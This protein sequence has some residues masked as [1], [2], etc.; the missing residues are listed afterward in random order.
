MKLGAIEDLARSAALAPD[1]LTV[2]SDPERIASLG[3]GKG[4]GLYALS[5]AGIAVPSWVILSSGLCTRFL[6]AAG[7]VPVIGGLLAAVGPGEVDTIAERI[8]DAI[9]GADDGPL[10]ELVAAALAE[11]GTECVAVRSS[12]SE[13]DGGRLSFAGQYSSFLNL[14][15]PAEIVRYVKKCWASAYS[16]RCLAYRLQHRLPLRVEATACILQVMVDAAKS[17]VMFTSNPL[18]N[19]RAEIMISAVYGLGEGLVSGLVDAD[20]YVIGHVDGALRRSEIGEKREHLVPRAGGGHE[21]VRTEPVLADALCLSCDEIA[22]LHGCATAI[23]RLFGVP[24][25]VEWAID[26]QGRL[27]ILQARPI[28]SGPSPLLDA[29]GAA[30]IWENSNISESFGGMTAPLTFSFA[31]DVYHQVFKEYCRILGVPRRML[32]HMDDWLFDMLGH[33]NGRV[34]YNLLNWYKVLRLAP[35]YRI[36]WQMLEFSIGAQES[37]SDA[38]KAALEPLA[39]ASPVFRRLIYARVAWRSFLYFFAIE[40]SVG[41]FLRDFARL[42]SRYDAI[43]YRQLPIGE[44]HRIFSAL[45]H[46][47]IAQFGRMIVLEQ[48]ISLT[49]GCLALL[50]RRWLPDAPTGFLLEMTRPQGML[51]SLEP[52]RR[53]TALVEFVEND[54][55]LLELV[56]TT[57]V[58][59]M[60]AVL[61]ASSLPATAAFRAEIEAYIDAFGYRCVNE[62][63]LEEPDIREDPTVFFAMLKSNLGLGRRETGRSE[64][65]G[66]QAY[67]QSRLGWPKRLVY[68]AVRRKARRLLEARERVRF[69]RTRVF[70]TARRMIKAMGEKLVAAGVVADRHDIF[71]LRLEELTGWFGGTVPPQELRPLIALRRQLADEQVGLDAPGRFETVGVIAS[72]DYARQGWRSAGMT[73]GAAPILGGVLSG[74]PCCPGSV[75]GTARLVSEPRDLGGG[76]LVTYR[77]DPGWCPILPSASALLIERGSPLT[78][79]AIVAREL[80]IPTI[81]QIKDLTRT[82]RS[83][84]TLA[85][86]ATAGTIGILDL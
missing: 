61:H 7:L 64:P 77:T 80:G 32:T 9:V 70:G 24:Q 6:E 43:D 57:E 68:L 22:L 46:R 82:V 13:E 28:T 53:M 12:G 42:H 30:R 11:L 83:G 62:M 45:R 2:H 67:L 75:T 85:V 3:G 58:G 47:F 69:C 4:R 1:L 74:T 17:G 19:D 51:E 38:A 16:G 29:Q 60:E 8:E 44:I 37:I 26:A 79:V 41:R 31:R 39:E 50:T 18:T 73:E 55:D 27:H 14:S 72:D 71:F 25:D 63:K 48:M 49:V 52:V 81:I 35:T 33:H 65:S 20:T 76:I 34:Y 54:R 21:T 84:M 15:D 66:A 5:R 23:E 59:A 56:R 40:G 78:H 36:N 10:A 86:D